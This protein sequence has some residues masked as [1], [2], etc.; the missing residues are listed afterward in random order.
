MLRFDNPCQVCP[1]GDFLTDFDL[2]LLK[3]AVCSGKYLQRLYLLMLQA[4]KRLQLRYACLL[5]G[6]LGLGRFY[7]YIEPLLFERIAILEFCHANTRQLK[8]QRRNVAI[9]CQRFIRV[10]LYACS[11][12]LLCHA[13]TLK[14]DFQVVEIGLCGA[15]LIFRVDGTLLE[16]CIAEFDNYAAGSNFRTRS[17]QNAF[18]TTLRRSSDDSDIFRHERAGAANLPEHWSAFYGVDPYRGFIH[19]GS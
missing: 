5:R 4:E 17:D 6:Q 1:R 11:G 15:K 13:I 19:R 14:L 9:L 7:V 2:H 16:F 18:D 3:H 12:R 8:I 10:R